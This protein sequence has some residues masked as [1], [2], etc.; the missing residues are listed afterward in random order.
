MVPR[1][2]PIVAAIPPTSN[3]CERL[4]SQCKLVMTPHRA[5]LLPM[6]F[7]MIVFLRANRKFWDANTL[8]RLDVDDT[9]DN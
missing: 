9:D 5:S 2:E 6:N 3:L 7:E 1:Y 4:S 8:M